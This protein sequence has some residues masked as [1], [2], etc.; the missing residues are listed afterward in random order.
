VAAP[1]N[2]SI[3]VALPFTVE[4]HA[5]NYWVENFTF[6]LNELPEFGHEY[7]SYVIEQWRH[8]NPDSTLHTALLALAHAVF[9]RTKHISNAL[10]KANKYYVKTL[11]RLKEIVENIDA[12]PNKDIDPLLL[13][14]MLMGSYENT[15]WGLNPQNPRD[16]TTQANEVGSRF[17]QNIFHQKGAGGLLGLRRSRNATPNLPLDGAIR[18]QLLRIGILRGISPAAFFE[19][20]YGE[21]SPMRELDALMLRVSQLRG[22]SLHLFGNQDLHFPRG[23]CTLLPSIPP[24]SPKVIALEAEVLDAELAIW[25]ENVPKDW[26][27]S[28]WLR[29]NPQNATGA[30]TTNREAEIHAVHEYTSHAH[31]TNWNRYRAVRMIVNSIH[32]R[33]LEE[34]KICPVEFD[35]AT[36]RQQICLQRIHDIG[37]ELC[38][39]VRYFF[40]T[41]STENGTYSIKI[42]D[43]IVHSEREI[44]P[45][46]AALVAWPLTVATCTEYVPDVHRS[47]LRERLG[48]VAEALGDKVLEDVSEMVEFKF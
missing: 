2:P 5:V 48:V 15:M 26:E 7:T 24:P 8:A 19:E 37:P 30:P 46:M 33:A 43:S 38:G 27:Y 40:N 22:N 31:A 18:R 36:A 35:G 34:M 28:T 14:I 1:Q 3:P 20:N 12:V 47:R 17:W 25:S 10:E 32:I 41:P 11:E 45:K 44:L 29:S 9:G 23:C 13:A 4:T 6:Q 21:T 39:G 42:G 16:L